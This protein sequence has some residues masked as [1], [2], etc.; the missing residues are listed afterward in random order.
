MIVHG[1][2]QDFLGLILSDDVIVEDP[3]DLRRFRKEERG[4]VAVGRLPRVFFREKGG[5]ELNAF[6]ADEQGGAGLAGI[7][8]VGGGTLNEAFHCALALAAE[9]TLPVL[10]ILRL[11]AFPARMQP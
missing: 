3:F 10:L 1:D 6:I 8:A 11:A 4:S 2:G 7:T 5:A 9:G